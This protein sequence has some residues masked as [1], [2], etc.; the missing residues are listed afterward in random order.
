VQTQSSAKD[1]AVEHF[2]FKRGATVSLVAF[3]DQAQLFDNGDG[4]VEFLAGQ[5]GNPKPAEPP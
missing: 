5:G 3:S 2:L 4:V 1:E